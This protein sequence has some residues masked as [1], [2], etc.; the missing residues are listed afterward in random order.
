MTYDSS[1][2]AL[3]SSRPRGHL[4]GGTIV[5]FAGQEALLLSGIKVWA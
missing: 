4:R 2:L 5:A 1:Q 3:L